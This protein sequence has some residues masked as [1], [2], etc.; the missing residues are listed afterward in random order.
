MPIN[1]WN[2]HRGCPERPFE[3]IRSLADWSLT[4]NIETK[5]HSSC[6]FTELR[7]SPEIFGTSFPDMHICI[8]TIKN[9]FSYTQ[10]I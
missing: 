6:G 7:H 10:E 1:Y 8:G 3:R 4:E 9:Q 5:S 2:T